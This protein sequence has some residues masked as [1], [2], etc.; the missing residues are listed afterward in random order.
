MFVVNGV[1]ENEEGTDAIEIP[2]DKEFK[3]L[4]T[5]SEYHHLCP[6]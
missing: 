3:A 5:H 6:R 2:T 1:Q 4:Q